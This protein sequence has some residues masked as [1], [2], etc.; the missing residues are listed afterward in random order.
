MKEV[1][2]TYYKV[3]PENAM[4]T[5]KRLYE[6]KVKKLVKDSIS[7]TQWTIMKTKI[8]FDEINVFHIDDDG[9]KNLHTFID[10]RQNVDENDVTL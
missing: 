7:S 9:D 6:F 4:F 1:C 3:Y 8:A 5:V 2:L 10:Y